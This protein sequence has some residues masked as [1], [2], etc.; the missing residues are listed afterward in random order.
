MDLLEAIADAGYSLLLVGPHHSQWEQRR[1]AELITRP[2]VHYVG[3]VPEEL[4]PSYIAATDIGITPYLDN[5]FNRASFPLKTL[6]YLVAGRPAVSTDL[7]A[8]RWLLGDLTSSERAFPPGRILA[9]AADRA[10]FVNAVRDIVGDP[11]RPDHTDTGQVV[12]EPGQAQACREFAARH[13]WSRR[14][15]ALAAAIGLT[16]NRGMTPGDHETAR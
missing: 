11:G 5:P 7:P 4:A 14:A 2:R 1:F 16:A 10:G 6:D 13:T 9:L 3:R 12:R 8:A 15:D